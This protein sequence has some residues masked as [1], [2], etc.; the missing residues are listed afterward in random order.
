MSGRLQGK[1]AIVTGGAQGQGRATA[2]LFADEGAVVYAC[3]VRPGDYEHSGVHQRA[4]DISDEAGW[5][6]LVAEISE[7]HGRLDILVNNAGI[8][9]SNDNIVDVAIDDLEKVIHVNVLGAT[10][11]A[12]AVIP[13]MLEGGS[14][15]IVNIISTLAQHAAPVQGAYQVSKGALR[16]L[17]RH[18]AV[19]YARSGVRVN[20]ILPGMVDTPM[21]AGSP[22]D[23]LEAAAAMIPMGRFAKPIEIAYGSLFLASD[24]SSFMTGS[25]VV[26][27]GGV[28]A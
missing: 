16:S 20:A 22:A 10:L 28:L 25:E 12:R 5:G 21:L 7:T 3:D 27:D 4:L 15:S 18:L 17:T 8:V 13:A 14:G 6:A 26:I 11:G 9:L 23:A 24:E 19:T 1:I 2:E